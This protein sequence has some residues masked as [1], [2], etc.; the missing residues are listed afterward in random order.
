MRSLVEADP[1]AEL[2]GF[3]IIAST[4]QHTLIGNETMPPGMKERIAGGA[5]AGQN[6][7]PN[8]EVKETGGVPLKEHPLVIAGRERMKNRDLYRGFFS[9]L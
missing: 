3:A 7:L 8:G 1:F 6:L 2:G 4:G 5:V 9:N